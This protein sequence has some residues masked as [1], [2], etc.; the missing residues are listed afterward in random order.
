MMMTADAYFKVHQYR[1]M[2]AGALYTVERGHDLVERIASLSK[3]LVPS[4][5]VDRA[6]NMLADL[7][8]RATSRARSWRMH[9]ADLTQVLR[10]DPRTVIVPLEHDH[11][12]ITLIDPAGRSTS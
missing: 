1:G 9:R 12:Q 7:Q 10:L 11:L 4:V 3:E 5:E 6:R 2:Y 8:Q